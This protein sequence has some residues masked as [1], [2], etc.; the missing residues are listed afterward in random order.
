MASRS[1]RALCLHPVLRRRSSTTK[2]VMLLPRRIRVGPSEADGPSPLLLRPSDC[3]EVNALAP[4][5]C[6]AAAPP[7]PPH[8][9]GRWCK[10]RPDCQRPQ[11]RVQLEHDALRRRARDPELQLPAVVHQHPAVLRPLCRRAP[12][13][14]SS[15]SVLLLF[16]QQPHHL[17]FDCSTEAADPD[18]DCVP[19]AD[20]A[21]WVPAGLRAGRA[22]VG[23]EGLRRER[24]AFGH[25]AGNA[26]VR[27]ARDLR[28]GKR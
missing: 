5:T 24:D 20:A 6:P 23:V 2:V 4:K 12:Q 26:N 3:S 27:P 1:R 19:G 10:R 7:L 11:F 22:S 18:R 15:R 13:C 14:R 21:G 16:I 28:G 9:S 25:P 8:P 17:F